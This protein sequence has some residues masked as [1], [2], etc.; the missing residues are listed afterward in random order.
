MFKA[1]LCRSC[2]QEFLPASH[3]QRYCSFE[4]K[5]LQRGRLTLVEFN[6]MFARQ[7]G[8]CAL[9]GFHGR[10]GWLRKGDRRKGWLVVDH[11]HET[12]HVRGLLCGDCNTALGRFGDDPG[13][14]RRAA[15]YL[16]GKLTG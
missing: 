4:C 7:R 5:L 14:L 12:G 1:R 3:P 11:C 10:K 8:R 15:E 6:E 16:E 2:G 13:R 9:C